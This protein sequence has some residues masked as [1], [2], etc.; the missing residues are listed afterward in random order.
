MKFDKYVDYI[1]KGYDN[2]GK[3]G[4]TKKEEKEYTYS[5]KECHTGTVP[6][7]VDPVSK[8]VINAGGSMRKVKPEANDLLIDCGADFMSSSFPSVKKNKNPV[9][10][11][12][13]PNGN[14]PN[15]DLKFWKDLVK[16]IRYEKKDVL[17]ACVGGHGRTGTCLAI[18]AALMLPEAKENPIIYIR[19]HYCKKAVE[20][21]KQYNYIKTLLN[22]DIP[23]PEY[24][25]H[26]FSS[27]VGFSSYYS[28][29]NFSF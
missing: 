9:V 16:V 11:I 18:L 28:Y 6:V 24:H 15:L 20:N 5:Y 21:T 7:F 29:D 23:E 27:S 17:I 14:V 2:F 22:L 10:E 25:H 4:K 12:D 8:V 19:E 3:K 1:K 26:S 13:I